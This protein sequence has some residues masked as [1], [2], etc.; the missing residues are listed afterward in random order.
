MMAWL[1][2]YTHEI[3]IDL[4]HVRRGWKTNIWVSDIARW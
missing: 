1:F 2:L 3:V 4:L